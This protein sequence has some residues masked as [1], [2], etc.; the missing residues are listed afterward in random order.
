MYLLVHSIQSR[1]PLDAAEGKIL[2]RLARECF[3]NQQPLILDFVNVEQVTAHF[4]QVLL[5]PLTNEFGADYLNQWLQ[6]TQV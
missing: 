5:C 2:A 4:C 1:T 3:F 6:I